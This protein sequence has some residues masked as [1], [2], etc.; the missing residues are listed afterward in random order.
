M[1][2]LDQASASRDQS[3]ATTGQSAALPPIEDALWYKEA[4]I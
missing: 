1:I 3:P 4:V 2:P